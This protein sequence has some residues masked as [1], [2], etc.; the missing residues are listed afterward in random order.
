MHIS[1]FTN[2]NT[3]VTNSDFF[4]RYIQEADAVKGLDHKTF[5][6]STTGINL[7]DDD[8]TFIESNIIDELISN[9][10]HINSFDMYNM[11]IISPMKGNTEN[12][13]RR[14]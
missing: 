4:F 3:R 2:G 8:E 13:T 11:K 5:Y 6:F 10:C 14:T 1:E 12:D 7:N 9:V